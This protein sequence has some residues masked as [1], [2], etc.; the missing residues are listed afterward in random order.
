M[1]AFA[2]VVIAVASLLGL[3]WYF[4]N[5]QMLK[6]GAADVHVKAP[7]TVT[8]APSNSEFVLNANPHSNW[9]VTRPSDQLGY[10]KQNISFDRQGAASRSNHP[11]VQHQ[12]DPDFQMP[13]DE[14]E[15]VG[16]YVQREMVQPKDRS[17]VKHVQMNDD[18]L[19]L[20]G[21]SEDRLSATR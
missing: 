18:L 3:G 2:V 14:N 6:S 4:S 1:R 11:N 7:P 10:Q 9:Q 13:S 12:E 19:V 17:K 8:G 15:V 16:K 20:E 5:S 21:R